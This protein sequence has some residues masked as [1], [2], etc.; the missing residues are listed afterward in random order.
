MIPDSVISIGDYA[1]EDC[2]DL[3]I[4][5]YKGSCAEK[6]AIENKILSICSNT[7]FP[8]VFNFCSLSLKLTNS[9]VNS[10]DCLFIYINRQVIVNLVYTF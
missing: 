8:F 3:T 6:Y 9:L 5:G 4:I 1:F 10:G 2:A 7:L